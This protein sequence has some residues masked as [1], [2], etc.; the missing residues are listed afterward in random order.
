[1][2]SLPARAYLLAC[3]TR[4]DRLPDRER[5]A[6]LVRAAALTDLVLRGLLTDDDGRPTVTGAGGTGHLVLDDILAEVTA[7]PHRKWRAWVRRGARGTLQSLEAQLDAAGTISLRTS[8]V[9]GLF[10]R[11]HPRVED[12]AAV[13]NLRDELLTALRGEGQV[14]P[15]VAALTSL[16]AAVELKTVLPRGERRQHK[17]RIEELEERAGAAVPALRKVIRELNAAR[18]ASIAASSGGGGG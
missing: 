13:A 7:D 1:M 18:A 11:R 8:K 15:E 14:T 17:A 4:R 16:A 6:L 5:V 9:L 12:R 10:P 2:L 3:D